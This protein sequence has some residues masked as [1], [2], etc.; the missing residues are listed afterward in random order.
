[1]LSL[2]TL[3]G[4]VLRS[5]RD[6]LR[7]LVAYHLFFTLLASSL[8]LPAAGWALAHLLGHFGRPL[9]SPAALLEILLTPGGQAWLLAALGVIFLLLYLQQ[10]GM[11]LVAVRPRDHH[12]RL[13]FEA[14]W[15]CL[16]RLP[17]LSGLVVLQVGSQLLLALPLVLT[18]VGLHDLILGHLDAYYV[19]QVRPPAFWGFLAAALPLTLLWAAAAA[20]LYT[21]WHLALPV[22]ILEEASPRRALARSLALTRGRGH[23]IALSI[24]VLLAAILALPL[25]ASMAFDA[26]FTPLIEK[27]PD[28]QA[29]LVPAMLGYVGLYVLVT[30]AIT[31]LG[32]A[33]NAL[34][35]AC[36]YL[37]LAHRE[38]RPPA[39]PPG[40][41]SGRLAWAV[42]LAVVLF[43]IGQAWLIV[44]RFE[45]REEVAIIAHRGSSLKAPENT[46]AAI[47]QAIV[48]GADLIEVDARLTADRQVV[49][50]HDSSL[51]RLA[52]D[53]RRIAD[54]DRASLAAVDVGSWFGDPFVGTR[55]SGLDEALVRT[56]GRAGLMIELKPTT[57]NG[58]LLVRRVLDALAEERLARLAC[59]ERATDGIRR[60]ACGEPDVLARVALATQA[61]PLLAEI[62]RQAPRARTILLAQL[63]MRG[64][65]PR[66]GFDALALR[67][68]R[69]DADEVRRAHHYGYRLHAWTINDPARMSRLIDLGVDGIITDRPDRLAAL[70]AERHRLG[71]GALMLV[72]LRNWLRE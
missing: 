27:L 65:L 5:L 18:L 54:I 60:A 33:A 17:A 67:H 53:P 21:R 28:H 50:H 24:L 1:M 30:L 25:A 41:H 71:D 20:T 46:L 39:P 42:E 72:K 11:T 37:R 13:A 57:G 7:P 58:D 10:A 48:D 4:D 2:T 31:F 55:I 64:T 29:V 43:A 9:L 44:N 47:D 69:I 23:G 12:V 62:E 3:G 45:L 36:L 70:I 14:L 35:G 59:R 56:R 34:M 26:L 16:R 61:Y 49:L 68:N 15:G 38:P 63:V 66:R 8:L 19:Q 22:L 6:H 51:A 52:G 40:T 32:I